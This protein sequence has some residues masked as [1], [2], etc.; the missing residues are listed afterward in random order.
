[1]SIKKTFYQK[2]CIL[3]LLKI[4]LLKKNNHWIIFFIFIFILTIYNQKNKTKTF[5]FGANGLF[6]SDQN[7]RPEGIKELNNLTSNYLDE[8]IIQSLAI[9]AK[10][11]QV[12]FLDANHVRQIVEMHSQGVG[13]KKRNEALDKVKDKID[14]TFIVMQPFQ[15]GRYEIFCKPSDKIKMYQDRL[16][17]IQS[18]LKQDEK[19]YTF[20]ISYDGSQRQITQL[21]NAI[22]TRCNIYLL[23]L[24][25]QAKTSYY[26]QDGMISLK[27]NI[28]QDAKE[29]S[30]KQGLIN[31][32]SVV[33]VNGYY[34]DQE[35]YFQVNEM[36][37]PIFDIKKILFEKYSKLDLKSLLQCDQFGLINNIN[38]NLDLLFL[39]PNPKLER[40]KATGVY[41]LKQQK[42]SLIFLANFDLSKMS[43][44]HKFRQLIVQLSDFGSKV[45]P[46]YAIILMGQFQ[47][48]NHNYSKEFIQILKQFHA[49]IKNILIF[50]MP[51][52]DDEPLPYSMPHTPIELEY[53][54]GEQI[55]QFDNIQS[56][57]NPIK[58]GSQGCKI[59][60]TRNDISKDLRKQHIFRE[61]SS[62][63]DVAETII[64][65]QYIGNFQSNTVNYK[66]NYNKYMMLDPTVD[67]VILA[68]M[69]IKQFKHKTQINDTWVANPGNFSEK[70]EFCMIIK[71]NL[72]FQCDTSFL[73]FGFQSF[74]S[75]S[76]WF[77]FQSQK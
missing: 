17:H 71:T 11:L 56:C 31:L 77:R 47:S 69:T 19:G 34:D 4:I 38:N 18:I 60:V 3:Y 44:V 73:G 22:N 5:Q 66:W 21:G 57:S 45:I 75:Y 14:N 61:E 20:G 37:V 76:L 25:Y 41:Q 58:I 24:I 1:M 72:G 12:E 40:Q 54:L 2:F 62:Y 50:F 70:G 52:F 30:L 29:N 51:S 13:V 63:E 46:T 55:E 43:T 53:L 59:V 32:Y 48:E 39:E 15:E 64:S 16:Q 10:D 49:F 7:L 23:G 42:Y 26:L 6:C 74:N 65:Q 9:Y 28:T 68:D 27:M 8:K 35:Q 33:V 67:Y 36:T